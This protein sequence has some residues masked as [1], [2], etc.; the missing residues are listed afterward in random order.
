[1]ISIIIPC[2]NEEKGIPNLINEL[3]RLKLN[4][5][6]EIIF[7]D[8]GSTDNTYELIRGYKIVK[9][10]TNKGIGEAMRSGFKYASGDLI[11]VVDSDCSYPLDVIPKMIEEMGDA[12]IITASPYHPG[13]SVENTSKFRLFLSKSASKLYDL[14]L[15]KGIYTYTAMVRVYK[16]EVIKDIEF[17]SSDFLAVTEILVNALKKGY[18]VREFPTILYKRKFGCSKMNLLKTIFR[19]IKYMLKL[20]LHI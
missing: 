17:K 3:N 11:A 12:D 9:H 5:K 1:M 16:K 19:H 20:V 14:I 8:D 4:Q 13:G 6:H 15:S 2:Y 10:E 7:V 18:K